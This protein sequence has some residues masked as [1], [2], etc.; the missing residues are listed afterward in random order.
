MNTNNPFQDSNPSGISGQTLTEGLLTALSNSLFTGTSMKLA[1]FSGNKQDTAEWLEN[2]ED[3]AR[4]AAWTKAVRAARFPAYLTG[5]AKS[6]YKTIFRE[7][8]NCGWDELRKAFLEEFL[9]CNYQGYLL[10]KLN[11]TV[12][13]YNESAHSYLLK[14]RE[15]CKRQNPNMTD[16]DTLTHMINGLHPHIRQMISVIEINSINELINVVKRVE[17]GLTQGSYPNTLSVVYPNYQPSTKPEQNLHT[18]PRST[19]ENVKDLLKQLTLAL[20]KVQARNFF[21]NQDFGRNKS[22]NT[23]QNFRRNFISN[24]ARPSNPCSNQPRFMNRNPTKPLNK[25]IQCTY[26]TRFGHI[27]DDCLLRQ[28]AKALQKNTTH[29]F[30]TKP[31]TTFSNTNNNNNSNTPILLLNVRNNPNTLAK[32]FYK[33]E[34]PREIATAIQVLMGRDPEQNPASRRCYAQVYI[35]KVPVEALIDSGADIT[36]I[37]LET[38]K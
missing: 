37:T 25:S 10:T 30:S 3:L 23:N 22:Q 12:Q 24:T 21:S 17:E 4:T 14:M 38:S 8:E 20:S 31:K 36:I 9:L 6:W 5:P 7:D 33:K 16:S 28:K 18:A 13:G 27:F 1:P 35:N 11:T 32:P 19:E 2:F 29:G 34:D 15:L 26:C